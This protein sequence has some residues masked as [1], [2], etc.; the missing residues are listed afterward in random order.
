MQ[1]Q[2]V[3]ISAVLDTPLPL[4]LHLPMIDDQ[5]AGVFVGVVD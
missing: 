3:T 1:E 2:E 5:K 4:P